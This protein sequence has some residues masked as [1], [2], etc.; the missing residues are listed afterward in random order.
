MPCVCTGSLL[1]VS[2]SACEFNYLRKKSESPTLSPV[3][4]SLAPGQ[5]H[6]RKRIPWYISVI[7]EKV[8]PTPGLTPQ[9]CA[10]WERLPCCVWGCGREP[11]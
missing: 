10:L 2:K 3:A 7:H 4:S 11:G 9:L 5:S 8:P 6:L 1:P